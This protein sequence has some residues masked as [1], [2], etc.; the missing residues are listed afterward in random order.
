MAFYK[1][2]FPGLIKPGLIEAM[3]RASNVPPKRFGSRP[4]QKKNAQFVRRY[5]EGPES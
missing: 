1:R 5:R 2:K 3:F 4:G